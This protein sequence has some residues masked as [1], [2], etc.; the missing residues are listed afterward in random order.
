MDKAE[1][2]SQVSTSLRIELHLLF[3]Y[4]YCF[5]KNFVK[6]KLAKRTVLNLFAH[7]AC[8]LHQRGI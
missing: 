6:N 3:E 5:S 1:A 7:A 8:E 2:L 4:D